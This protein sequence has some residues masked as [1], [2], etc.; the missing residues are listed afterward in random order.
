M[1]VFTILGVLVFWAACFGAGY[2]LAM[3]RDMKA[4]LDDLTRPVEEDCFE[5]IAILRKRATA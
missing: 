1:I 4:A 2:A 5:V 3:W